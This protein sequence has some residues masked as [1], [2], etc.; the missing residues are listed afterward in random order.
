MQPSEEFFFDLL[1]ATRF[2]FLKSPI[3]ELQKERKI[4]WNYSVCET[5]IK[6]KKG[7]ILGLNWGAS[8]FPAYPAQTRYPVDKKERDWRFL[9]SSMPYI[10]KYFGI[11]SISEVNYT[12]L[13]FFRS[14]N[15]TF[16]TH[17]DWKNAM[18]LL[19]KYVKYIKPEW[20]VL[21]GNTGVKF[22]SVFSIIDITKKISV[23]DKKNNING[24]KGIFINKYPFYCLPHPQAHVSKN[25]R[26]LIWKK[27][28]NQE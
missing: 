27:V 2:A 9:N 14:L 21:L 11:N 19:V 10:K 28:L 5:T 17:T 13:C 23:S 22:L 12:N 16:L 24:Y 25:V 26:N 7:I 15:I 20:I 18:P 8:R 6:K 4:Q 1:D 3:Y